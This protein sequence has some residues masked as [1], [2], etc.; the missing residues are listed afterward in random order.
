LRG[1]G[2]EKII[3]S[4]LGRLKKELADQLEGDPVDFDKVFRLASKIV[5]QDK[6]FVRFVADAAIIP[7]LGRELVA[8]QET[9]LAELVK[10]AYDSDATEVQVQLSNAKTKHGFL[11]VEDNGHGMTRDQLVQGFMRLASDEK[12][13]APFSPKY[14][15]LRAGRKG[16]GR[17]A[18]DRLGDKLTLVTQTRTS[19]KALRLEIGWDSFQQGTL[20]S[21]VASRISEIP[22]ERPSGTTLLISD[23]RDTWSDAEL[24]RVFRYVSG[25][26]QPFPVADVPSKSDSDPGFNVVLS[27]SEGATEKTE[28]VADIF[29]EILKQAIAEINADI[30]ESGNARWSIKSRRFGINQKWEKVGLDREKPEPLPNARNVALRAYYYNFAPE[31]YGPSANSLRDQLARNGG[32]RVYRNGYRVLPYGESNDDWLQLDETYAKRSTVLAPIANR[33]FLGIVE[34]NDRTGRVFEET[35]SREGLIENDA[36][37]ELQTICSRILITGAQRLAEVRYKGGKKPRKPAIS[38][39]GALERGRRSATRLRST[40]KEFRRT[41][42]IAG[43]GASAATK[44]AL[45]LTAGELEA[46]VKE[47]V[48]AAAERDDLAAEINLLRILASMGLAIAEFTHDFSALAQ[49]ME[50]DLNRIAK[51]A[52]ETPAIERAVDRLRSR[53]QLTRAYSKYFGEMVSENASRKLEPIELYRFALDFKEGVEAMLSRPGMSLSVEKPEQYDIYTTPMHPSEWSSVLLN[54]LTNSMKAVRRAGVA[55]R[56]LIRTGRDKNDRVFLEFADNGDGIA[57]ENRTRVFDA[58]FSTTAAAAGSELDTAH[59][60]G[61]GLGLKIVMDIAQGVGGEAEVIDPPEGFKACLR[62]TVP[63]AKDEELPT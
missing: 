28:I 38:P 14:K 50:L 26:L 60:V 55:G 24:R 1:T 37:R 46:A 35:S 18:A 13:R 6:E 61:T 54:F 40:V 7:R 31:I 41:A 44:Q 19:S 10:N 32:I 22:K 23:L 12:I 48:E 16:I 62:V 51:S 2:E 5:E 56:F 21:T 47:I 30:D 59:A 11:R 29:T 49:T 25:L 8:K 9:A 57:K 20:L 52:E 42:E 15:R 27:R 36:F 45:L 3:V 63:A 4:D 17:F 33:N 43:S 39:A 53:F 34:I 58:F